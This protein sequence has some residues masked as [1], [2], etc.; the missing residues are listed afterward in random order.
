M[1]EGADGKP[2][3]ASLTYVWRLAGSAQPWTYD[4]SDL[5]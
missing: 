3:T 1:T 4:T 5:D 2:S